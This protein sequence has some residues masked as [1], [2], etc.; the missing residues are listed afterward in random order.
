MRTVS[1]PERVVQMAVDGPIR[2]ACIEFAV[3]VDWPEL[4]LTEEQV[5]ANAIARAANRPEP[6]PDH[7]IFTVRVPY[8][9]RSPNAA[10]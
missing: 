10:L 7:S 4:R 8:V 9:L 6:Y 3:A 1:V 2:G 5:L